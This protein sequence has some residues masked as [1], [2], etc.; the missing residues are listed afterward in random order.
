MEKLNKYGF[1]SGGWIFDYMDR[2]A[3]KCL[4]ASYPETCNE[5][6]YTAAA[7]VSFLSQVC[8]TSCI[9][10]EIKI[11]PCGKWRKSY[12]VLVYLRQ[13]NIRRA[14]ANFLFVK[15]K[16]NKCKIKDRKNGQTKL[17]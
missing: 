1:V 15:A 9:S 7:H 5:N 14:E 3:L 12:T 4:N 17:D 10:A 8:D 11:I 2:A 13:G 16:E 6:I